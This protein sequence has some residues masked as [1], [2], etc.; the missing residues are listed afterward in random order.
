MF[1]H[2]IHTARQNEQEIAALSMLLGADWMPEVALFCR[3]DRGVAPNGI[4]WHWRTY[5]DRQG[6]QV[7]RSDLVNSKVEW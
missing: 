6:N 3:T 1:L 5:Y 7:K 2:N 4:P